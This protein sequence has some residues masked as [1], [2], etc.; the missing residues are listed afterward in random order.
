MKADLD[1]F[2]KSK[3][4]YIDIY[5]ITTGCTL[6]SI[7]LEYSSNIKELELQVLLHGYTILKRVTQAGYNHQI[8]YNLKHI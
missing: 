1:I 7:K 5:D 6:S 2:P 8:I 3:T 4:A